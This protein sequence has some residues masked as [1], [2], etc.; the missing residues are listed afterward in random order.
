[1]GSNGIQLHRHPASIHL[2]A[3]GPQMASEFGSSKSLEENIELEVM[4]SGKKK[5]EKLTGI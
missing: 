3:D 5:K 4:L 1:M 2:G